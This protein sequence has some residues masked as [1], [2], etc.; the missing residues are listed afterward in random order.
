MST[1]YIPYKEKLKDPQWLEKRGEIVERDNYTCRYCA[2]T[3]NLQ[4][5]H[6][7]YNAETRNPWDVEDECL[8]TLC[9]TCHF[10]NHR[11]DLSPLERDL[12]KILQTAGFTQDDYCQLLLREANILIQKYKG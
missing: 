12:Y 3:S 6:F 4:V 2:T 9:K 5:H 8:V 10:N 11:L 7:C 1:P